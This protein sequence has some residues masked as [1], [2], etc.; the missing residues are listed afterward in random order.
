MGM[1]AGGEIADLA[2]MARPEIGL[3]TWVHGVHLSRMG[4]LAAI[5][6]AKGELVEALPSDGVAVLNQDDRRVRR[7]ADRTAARVMTY[8]LSADA[9]V[10]ADE[11]A[12]AGFD[13]MRFTLRLPPSRGGRPTRL[14]ARIPG[15]G[16]L[17]VHNA[18]AGA[19]V[20]H[21]AGLDP[22]VIVHAL[23]AGWSASHRGQVIKLGRMTLIDDSYNASPPSVTAAL[24]LLA[25]LPGRRVAVLGEMLEL[26]KGAA[27]GHREVGTAA[28]AT[29]DLLVVVGAGASGIAAGAKAAGLDA[30]RILEARDREAALDLL[31][32]RL[33]DGDVIL[34]KAS[35]G[36]E[37]DVLVDAL[38][39][40]HGG[41]R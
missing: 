9:D 40:E 5:E 34:V 25:G 11:V 16:K 17:S 39:A 2:R 10:G 8:G 12:S 13:G 14:P 21:A 28:A 15:L 37:L 31:R 30:S 7:M 1:Y 35:R 29:V 22:A 20:G 27:S 18:L 24:D 38:R 33:R 3:V 36:V 19:A 4:S 32:S 26:G 23:G 41:S 6:Q